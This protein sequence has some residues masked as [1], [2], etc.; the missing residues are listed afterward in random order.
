MQCTDRLARVLRE[1]GYDFVV[2]VTHMTELD[3]HQLALEAADM[4]IILGAH[5]H[6]V[7][8]R[9][10]NGRYIVKSGIDFKV[11]PF[12]VNVLLHW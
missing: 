9:F 5:D 1:E 11:G 6:I 7:R 4:D 3:D 2:A 12:S 8:N 10:V